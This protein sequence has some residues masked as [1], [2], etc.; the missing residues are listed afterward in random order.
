[1]C[2]ESNRIPE[3]KPALISYLRSQGYLYLGTVGIDAWFGWPELLDETV[4]KKMGKKE[5]A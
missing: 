1:M 4:V 2:V 5:K 3:G